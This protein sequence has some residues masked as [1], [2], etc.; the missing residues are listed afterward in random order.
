MGWPRYGCGRGVVVVV[1]VIVV[2]FGGD[3]RSCRFS[4]FVSLPGGAI[5]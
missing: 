3:D 2:G 4:C 1:V 5:E